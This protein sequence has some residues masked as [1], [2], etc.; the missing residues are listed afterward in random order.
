M[1]LDSGQ[2]PLQGQGKGQQQGGVNVPYAEFVSKGGWAGDAAFRPGES[3]VVR[4]YLI[5][6]SNLQT[7]V[8]E[9]IGYSWKGLQDGKLHRALPM[10]DPHFTWCYATAITAIRGISF[11]GKNVA[12]GYGPFADYAYAA[13]TVLF[14]TPEYSI[15]SDAD[16]TT[17]DE[18]YVA[19]R[20]DPDL[21][22]LQLQEGQLIYD[23]AGTVDGAAITGNMFSGP[24]RTI[25][26][27][28]LRLTW[29][30][31][32]V[33]SKGLFTGEGFDDGGVPTK[34][35]DC[36]NRVNVADIWGF[37]AQTLL[38]NPP[39]FVPYT[40]PV[41]SHVLNLGPT[42]PPRSFNVQFNLVHFDPPTGTGE[43]TK[44]WNLAPHPKTGEYFRVKFKGTMQTTRPYYTVDM[45][46]LFEMN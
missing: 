44:G 41:P 27:P 43:T 18:R 32:D 19:K 39:V 42:T 26:L 25:L 28:K 7:F 14:A 15:K 4:T 29:T 3:R 33:P 46:K 22:A 8:R 12:F 35:M 9:V 20:L 24:G 13:V 17:E 1:G 45:A 23:T 2:F 21:E 30:W 31:H 5:H 37:T 11:S 34:I 16:V 40:M 36:V 10:R 38:C 6:F